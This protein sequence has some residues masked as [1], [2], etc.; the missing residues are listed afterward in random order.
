[1]CRN[2][3]QE[4]EANSQLVP[5][6]IAFFA[7]VPNQMYIPYRLHSCALRDVT[8]LTPLNITKKNYSDRVSSL[9]T[10]KD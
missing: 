10:D 2:T 9:R 8:N 1:M 6:T 3:T 7:K 5:Q 4:K